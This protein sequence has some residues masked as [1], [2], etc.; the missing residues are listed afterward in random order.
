MK[1]MKQFTC[2]IRCFSLI[3]TLA[4]GNAHGSLPMPPKHTPEDK[5]K[6]SEFV[7][8]GEVTSITC[9]RRDPENPVRVI[10]FDGPECGEDYNVGKNTQCCAEGNDLSQRGH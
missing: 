7:V 4:M 1:D 10:Y 3:W 2:R 5:I 8:V 6:L 9:A